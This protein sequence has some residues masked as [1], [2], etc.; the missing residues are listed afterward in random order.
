MECQIVQNYSYRIIVSHRN[1]EVLKIISTAM[2][3]IIDYSFI[4]QQDVNNNPLPFKPGQIPKATN[5][6]FENSQQPIKL[7]GNSGTAVDEWMFRQILHRGF[8]IAKGCQASAV[9]AKQPMSIQKNCFELGK[10]FYLTWQA[11]VETESF[12]V[13]SFHSDIKVNLLSAPVLFHLNCEPSLHKTLVDDSNA[14]DGI[15]D[16]ILFHKVSN[17]PGM[18]Q[19]RNL[20]AKLKRKTQNYLQHFAASDE[21]SKIENILSS[22]D[23]SV[24]KIIETINAK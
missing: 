22:N 7:E 15:D 19:A 3:D 13:E 1:D 17:G 2:C 14:L 10:Y 9:L 16:K 20:T 6:S 24:L 23:F 11:F 4:G 12:E 18:E 8:L 5:P 21:K